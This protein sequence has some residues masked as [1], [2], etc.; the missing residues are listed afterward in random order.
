[1]IEAIALYRES[2]LHEVAAFNDEP[3]A[4]HWFEKRI[5]PPGLVETKTRASAIPDP[6]APVLDNG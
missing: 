6:T 1:V 3:L 5:R 4:H 2:G